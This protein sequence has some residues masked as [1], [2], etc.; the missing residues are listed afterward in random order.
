MTNSMTAA[1]LQMGVPGSPCARAAAL[2]LAPR[3]YLRVGLVDDLSGLG[4]R[5]HENL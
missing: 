5:V 3:T 4:A 1:L 2:A